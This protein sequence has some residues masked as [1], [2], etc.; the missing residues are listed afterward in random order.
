[1]LAPCGLGVR[2]EVM[3]SESCPGCCTPLCLGQTN[4]ANGPGFKTTIWARGIPSTSP[5]AR[6]RRKIESGEGG[7]C[8]LPCR[9]RCLACS[10][11]RSQRALQDWL[12]TRVASAGHYNLRFDR[13]QLRYARPAPA[14][15]GKVTSQLTTTQ[16]RALVAIMFI[17]HTR[18]KLLIPRRGS[19]Q[20]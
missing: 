5:R 14:S 6:Y 4:R 10:R 19:W 15:R 18:S 12:G 16:S 17:T 9:E 8:G 1:L 13:I 20:L 11:R 7:Q 3:S 2:P